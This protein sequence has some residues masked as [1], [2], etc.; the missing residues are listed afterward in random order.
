MLEESS[1]LRAACGR[2][3]VL[4]HDLRKLGNCDFNKSS[5]GGLCPPRD[6]MRGKFN[7][8]C[9]NA[10][11]E[12]N[13]ENIKVVLNREWSG[14]VQNRWYDLKCE[15]SC[16]PAAN[17]NFSPPWMHPL[18][19]AP[20]INK[21]VQ[22]VKYL[23]A[24]KHDKK[25]KKHTYMTDKLITYFFFLKSIKTVLIFS[26]TL[27]KEIHVFSELQEIFIFIGQQ[28]TDRQNSKV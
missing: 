21:I 18:S 14:R 19:N 3:R 5:S 1:R 11:T 26:K 4:L 13:L 28:K 27:S 9:L 24:N 15:I 10:N 6:N 8:L 23:C 25:Y 22:L 12:E 2:I 7:L 16:H 17:S 20:V